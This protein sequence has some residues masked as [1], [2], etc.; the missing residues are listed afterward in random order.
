MHGSLLCNLFL[1]AYFR[2]EPAITTAR[3]ASFA[4]AAI[5]LS[6][7]ARKSHHQSGNDFHYFYS[8]DLLGI[9]NDA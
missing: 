4:C 7:T 8:S 2:P 6:P 3:Y 9:F 5:H 1:C